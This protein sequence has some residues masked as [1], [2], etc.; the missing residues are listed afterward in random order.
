MKPWANMCELFLLYL[1]SAR[2]SGQ[3]SNL[4][5]H[6]LLKAHWHSATRMYFRHCV[7]QGGGGFW[8]RH[9]GADAGLLI[10]E[11]TQSIF[12]RKVCREDVYARWLLAMVN[13]ISLC[14]VEL[15]TNTSKF[16]GRM[17]C[18]NTKEWASNSMKD[19]YYILI[20]YRLFYFIVM[21]NFDNFIRIKL[22]LKIG[23]EETWPAFYL[24]PS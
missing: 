21:S 16:F 9:S 6:L 17:W 3:R 7:S 19:L 22:L 1:V 13:I 12:S 8:Q 18:S 5:N 11:C 10:I 2:Y 23:D 4:Y 14:L 24:K 15:P 20:I